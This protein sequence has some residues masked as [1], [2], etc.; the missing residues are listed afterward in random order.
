MKKSALLILF[1]VVFIDLVGFGIVIPILPYYAKEFGASATQLGWLMA[2]YSLMQF[3]FAPVWGRLSDSI[4][5][6]PVLLVSIAGTAASMTFLGFAHS[7]EWLFIGRIFAGICG[8]NISTAFAFAADVTTPE[9]RSKGMGA[10]GAAF[11]LGFI[12]GPAIGGLLSPY[13]YSAPMFA[14]AA[15]AAINL[16]F[17]LV[18]LE[19]PRITKQE[20]ESHRHKRFDFVEIKRVLQNPITSKLILVYFLMILAHTQMEVVFGIYLKDFFS[21]DA[22]HAGILLAISGVTMVMMQGGMI[23]R[24]TKKFGET[25]LITI[26]YPGMIIGLFGFGMV[27]SLT[28]LVISLIVLSIAYGI[29]SPTMNALASHSSD[30]NHQ[31]STMGVMQS[32]GSLSRVMG[33]PLAGFFYDHVKPTSP[34]FVGCAC[35]S[36]ALLVFIVYLYGPMSKLIESSK[37]ATK[38]S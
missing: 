13:G 37:S 28:G 22:K 7:L 5:R 31:G 32:A 25:K 36:A 1:L 8:A 12:F 21:L 6:K 17:A 24:L 30:K 9:N 14:G 38:A 18:K 23:G 10:V 16:V 4:G 29:V 15:L 27:L 33:P 34:F 19:E 2:S 3:F 35:L 11:G 20:R 26:G